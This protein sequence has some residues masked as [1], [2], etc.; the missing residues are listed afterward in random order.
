[1]TVRESRMV[2]KADEASLKKL[3]KAAVVEVLEERRDLVREAL[4]DA[5]EDLG[6]IEAIKQGLHSAPI[7]RDAVFRTLRK[8][9]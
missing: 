2:H 6:M 9:P 5:V 4:A 1:M 8:R 3:V 7:S